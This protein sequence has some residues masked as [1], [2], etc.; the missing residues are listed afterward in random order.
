M[1]SK[2]RGNFASLASSPSALLNYQ[3]PAADGGHL[4][5]RPSANRR[6]DLGRELRSL[7]TYAD[8]ADFGTASSVNPMKEKGVPAILDGAA[9]ADANF[10]VL[11]QERRP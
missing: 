4:A 2:S 3:G 7:L 11:F 6:C 8:D 5:E 1:T 9:E 10:R